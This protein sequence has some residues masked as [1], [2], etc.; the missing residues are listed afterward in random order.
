MLAKFSEK[1]SLTLHR[2]MNISWGKNPYVE[3]C[4]R[5]GR[6]GI[7]WLLAAVWKLKGVRQNTDRGRCILCLGAE[8]VKYVLLDC[9]ETRSFRIKCLNDEWLNANK[10]VAYRKIMTYE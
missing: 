6:S 5:K 4:S 2:E 7:A 10:E 8:G 3:G 9:S 1:N